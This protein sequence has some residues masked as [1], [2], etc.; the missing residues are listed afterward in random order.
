MDMRYFLTKRIAFVRQ[1]TQCDWN[2]QA[3]ERQVSHCLRCTTF[4][5]PR[6]AD[7]S[8]VKHPVS[9]FERA[10]FTQCH[11][12]DQR[13]KQKNLR[14]PRPKTLLGKISTRKNLENAWKEI[15]QFAWDSSHGT[16]NETIQEFRSNLKHNLELIRKQLL[17]G[18]HK[19]RKLRAVT[20]LKKGKKKKRPLKIADIRDRVVQRAFARVLERQLKDVFDLDNDASIA[21]LKGKG[22][23]IAIRRLLNCHQNGCNIVFEADIESFFGTVNVDDLLYRLIFPNLQDDTINTLIED[24][25]A[26]EIG[27]REELS[28]EDLLLFPEEAMGLPQGGYLSPLLSNIYLSNFDHVM[29][30]N[31]F[32]LIRY[33]DDFIVMCKSADD[34]EIAYKLAKQLLEQDLGLKLHPRNGED[35]KAKTR[36]IELGKQK[37]KFLG[38]LFDGKRILPDPDKKRELSNKLTAIR[39]DSRTVLDLLS[40]TRNLLDGWISAYSFTNLSDDY[41]NSI[42]AEVNKILSYTLTGLEWRL[43]PRG[44]LSMVQR[45]NSGVHPVAWHLNKVRE[46]Y[47]ASDR[48]LLEKYW[49]K[50]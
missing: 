2:C 25:F 23:R 29:L 28:D 21:Y 6:D 13:S 3:D 50:K 15:S 17:N 34:A 46:N 49:I 33:A 18:E 1:C 40:R 38:V 24:A 45:Y 35:K 48:K 9:C 19:F 4:H 39:S 14:M 42:D 22:V 12:A 8:N 30:G 5:A 37:I 26:I 10:H 47:S 43:K 11:E 36:I 20:R 27:N 44:Q 7:T 32:S 16:S 31:G 41:L